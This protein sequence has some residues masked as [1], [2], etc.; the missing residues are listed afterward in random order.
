MVGLRVS[1]GNRKGAKLK[2]PKSRDIRPTTS[3]VKEY[4]FNILGEYL[5]DK[6]VLDLFSGTGNLGIEALSRGAE[7]VFFVDISQESLNLIED[8]IKKTG[9]T[10]KAKI[11]KSDVLSYILSAERNDIM[12]DIILADPPFR[13]EHLFKLCE[14]CQLNAILKKDGFFIIEHYPEIKK[15][16]SNPNFEL[17]KYKSFGD[18]RISIFRKREKGEDSNLSGHV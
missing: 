16:S 7:T 10:D 11:I 1:G 9:F 6:K 4:I 17:V 13:Y 14:S 15:D 18:K 3:L 8:N 5:Y 2:G 12:F